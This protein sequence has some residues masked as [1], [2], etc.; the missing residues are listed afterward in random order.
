M[1]NLGTM[2][3]LAGAMLA[4]VDAGENHA[5][6]VTKSLGGLYAGASGTYAG[7]RGRDVGAG[8]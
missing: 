6:T 1:E 2:Q 8:G 7:V 5:R 3:A 4:L